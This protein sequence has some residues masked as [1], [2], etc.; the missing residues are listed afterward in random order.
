MFIAAVTTRLRIVTSVMVVPHRPP[1]LTA[2]LLAT[3]DVLSKGR[4]TLGI[5]VSAVALAGSMA[6]SG[7]TQAMPAD[8][9]AAYLFVAAIAIFAPLVATRLHP[10]AGSEIS[11]QIEKVKTG[12]G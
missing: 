1:M 9:S 3:L 10:M 11:G 8:F 6:F 4:L 2:K 7:H 5:G 12:R